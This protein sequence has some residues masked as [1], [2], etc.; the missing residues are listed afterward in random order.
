MDTTK[1]IIKPSIKQQFLLLWPMLLRYA[2]LIGLYV[3][4]MGWNFNTMVFG[5]PLLTAFVIDFGPAIALNIEYSIKTR[6]LIIE[7]DEELKTIS[8]SWHKTKRTF[9]FEDI[10]SLEYY[11]SYGRGSG[12]YSFE[13]YRYYKITFKDQTQIPITSLMMNKIQKRVEPLLGMKAEKNPTFL[14]FV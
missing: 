11:S 9:S 13:N 8:Y 12:W 5:A 7:I 4:Y 2:F 10:I 14:P 6:G 3:H 1:Y